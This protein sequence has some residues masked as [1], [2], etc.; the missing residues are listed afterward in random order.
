LTLTG[1]PNA[2]MVVKVSVKPG[3]IKIKFKNEH[4]SLS[5]AHVAA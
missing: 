2:V 3:Q 5:P 1:T 4:A